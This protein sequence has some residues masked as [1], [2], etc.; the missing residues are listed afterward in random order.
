MTQVIEA[1]Y[2]DGVL[3]P[4]ELV[5]LADNQRVRV[6]IEQFNGTAQ[7]L[8]DMETTVAGREAALQ[9]L[10]EE[11]EHMKFHLAGPLPTRDELHE[12][13]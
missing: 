3:R 11:I 2:K 7:A 1:I 5:D 8:P 6:T 4:L 12:R 13:R 9:E 10:F